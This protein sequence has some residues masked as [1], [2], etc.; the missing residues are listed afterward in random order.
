MCIYIVYEYMS[1]MVYSL[2]WQNNTEYS[3]VKRKRERKKVNWARKRLVL[4]CVIYCYIIHTF[5]LNSILFA[6]KGK[7]K[8]SKA[9][10]LFS[11]N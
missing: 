3:Y 4:N 7:K 5:G 10:H 2:G 11:Y 9:L 1:F 8:K 6:T